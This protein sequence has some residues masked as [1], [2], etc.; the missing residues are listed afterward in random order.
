MRP[1]LLTI[2]PTNGSVL[3]AGTNTLSVIFNPSDSL[4]YSSATDMVLLV[5]SPAA[6]TVTAAGTNRAY[7]QSNPVFTGAIAGLT[8]GDNI[9]A[10][11]NSTATN[12]SAVGM[13]PITPSLNDPNNRQTNYTVS[14]VDGTLTVT[15]AV[16]A[17]IWTNPLP[18]VYGAPLTS[19]PIKRRH[20]DSGRF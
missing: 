20:H 8:N 5:V 11:Y 7:G 10:S 17:I 12:G 9:T 15:Q 4:D 16:A 6:L 14:L 13:Y 18:L 1:A 2:I 3:D 19:Q